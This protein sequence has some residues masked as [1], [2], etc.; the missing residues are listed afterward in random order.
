[1]KGY[2]SEAWSW[3]ACWLWE[4]SS[5]Y[6]VRCYTTLMNIPTLKAGRNTTSKAV[7]RNANR[8]MNLTKIWFCFH[9]SQVFCQEQVCCFCSFLNILGCDFIWSIVPLTLNYQPC[10]MTVAPPSTLCRKVQDDSS[11]IWYPGS[12]TSFP[13]GGGRAKRQRAERQFV[14]EGRPKTAQV[15]SPAQDCKNNENV[16]KPLSPIILYYIYIYHHNVL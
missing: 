7:V 2:E 8:D 5:L 10:M 4:D 6:S 14:W 1:M 9:R 16:I 12:Q 15:F 13:K 11:E 3:P